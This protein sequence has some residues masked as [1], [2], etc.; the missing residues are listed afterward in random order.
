MEVPAFAYRILEHHR[1]A[2]RLRRPGGQPHRQHRHRPLQPGRRRTGSSCSAGPTSPST[3]PSARGAIRRWC[4]TRCCGSRSASARAPS[5]PCARPSRATGCACTTS[6]KW[7]CAPAGC[8]RSRPS[9]AGSTRPAGSCRRPPSSPWPR[10]PAWWWT[11]GAGSSP[12]RAA[13]WPSG[14]GTTRNCRWSCGSTCRRRSSSSV[15][16]SSSWR[17]ACGCTAFRASGCASK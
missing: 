6:P 12:R 7:I 5:S 13:S 1:R 8:S 4:S 15:A 14:A 2:H 16:W 10:R 17:T 11:W 3:P 9:C